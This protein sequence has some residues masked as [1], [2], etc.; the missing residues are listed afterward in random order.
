[1]RAAPVIV[2]H[3]DTNTRDL[4]VSA[5]RE[6][7]LQAVGFDDPM[8]ALLAIET[9]TRVRVLISP[10]AF[11]PGKL[12]GAALA[13]MLKF[14]LKRRNVK[15]VFVA[16]EEHREYVDGEGEFL[17][18]PLDPPVLVD[19]VAR[20]LQRTDHHSARARLSDNEVMQ[21]SG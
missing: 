5:L 6:A 12:N 13:R 20:L 16:P 10:V 15:T 11:A 21:T 4:A 18:A 9:D 3:D 17:P 7:G 1:M 19:T 2:V 8:K 14:K